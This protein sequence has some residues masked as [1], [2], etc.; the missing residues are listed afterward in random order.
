M[1]Y[2]EFKYY[3]NSIINVITTNGNI[4]KITDTSGATKNGVVGENV[5]RSRNA[6]KV[7]LYNNSSLYGT[8][9][10]AVGFGKYID[11]E[12]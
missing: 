1:S 3:S 7:S 6:Y 8:K 12:F 10:V 4:V 9:T 2:S 11:V 5:V